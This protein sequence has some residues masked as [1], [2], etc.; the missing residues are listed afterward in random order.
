MCHHILPYYS[1]RQ[2]IPGIKHLDMLLYQYC[3]I[4]LFKSSYYFH[5]QYEFKMKDKI[6]YKSENSILPINFHKFIAIMNDFNFYKLI[7]NQLCDSDKTRT[8]TVIPDQGIFLPH[9]LLHKLTYLRPTYY[10]QRQHGVT[11]L[12]TFSNNYCEI[13]PI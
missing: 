9:L 4:A 3:Y 6:F 13:P 11:V 12:N 2:P 1:F 10:T 8:C 7:N 5:K